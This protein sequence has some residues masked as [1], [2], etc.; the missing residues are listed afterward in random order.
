[1][2]RQR[3]V[4]KG[5]RGGQQSPFHKC[6]PGEATMI[7]QHLQSKRLTSA[8]EYLRI[9]ELFSFMMLREYSK[10]EVI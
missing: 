8:E 4:G 9:R 3:T 6:T 5:G 2:A 10:R 7:I 1:M